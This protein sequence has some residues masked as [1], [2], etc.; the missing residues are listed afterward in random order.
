MIVVSLPRAVRCPS[1]VGRD[2]ELAAMAALFDAISA[3]IGGALIL[4]GDAGQ[5]KSRLV[6]EAAVRA[7]AAGIR[8][9]TG[10]ASA[11]AAVPYRVLS[12]AL[13]AMTGRQGPP[14]DRRIDPYRAILGKL[15]PGWASEAEPADMSAVAAGEAVLAVAGV[16][17]EPHGL[18]IALEDLHWADGETLAV[19]EYVTDNLAGYPVGLLLTSRPT[20]AAASRLGRQ[21]ASRGVAARAVLAPLTDGEAADMAA[22]CAAS[23]GRELALE[24]TTAVVTRSAGLPLLIEDLIA[25]LVARPANVAATAMPERFS[26]VVLQRLAALGAEAQQVVQAAAVLGPRFDWRLLGPVTTLAE[27]GIGA[28]IREAMDAQL[29][30]ADDHNGRPVFRHALTADV[31]V[32]DLDPSARA[33]LQLRAADALA[34]SGS[35]EPGELLALEARLRDAAGDSENAAALLIALA[36]RAA[37]VGALA[38]AEQHL[39][40]AVE[41][42]ADSQRARTLLLEVL[43][44]RG[45]TEP[46]LVLGRELLDSVRLVGEPRAV[47]ELLMA[48]AC[49]TAGRLGEARRHLTGAGRTTSARQRAEIASVQARVILADFGPDRVVAA[50]HLAHRAV[51]EAE[52]A[53]APELMCESLEVVGRCARLRDLDHARTAF[54]RALAVAD[55]HRLALWRIRALSELGTIEMF[56][57]VEPAGLIEA[58]RA[59]AAAGA[60]ATAA[61]VDVN[62]AAVHTMRAEFSP[63]RAAAE[64]CEALARRCGLPD[65]RAAG[66]VFQ[67]VV[68]THEGRFADMRVHVRAAEQLAGDDPDVIVGT[69]AMC[70]A[71]AALLREERDDARYAFATA[72]RSLARRPA[73]AIN[74]VDGPWLLLQVAAGEAGMG[75]VDDYAATQALGSRW[76]A[77][78][79]G[80]SR[81]IALGELGEPDAATRAAETAVTAGAPMPLFLAMGMRL[82]AERA[83]AAG[84][85]RPQPWLTAAERTFAAC[86]HARPAAACRDLL[87]A[88]GHRVPRQRAVD[89]AVPARL[90][91][92]GVTAREFDVFALVAR[93]CTNTEI[94]GR[95]Y[96]SPRTVEKH[97]A[98]LLAKTGTSSRIDLAR[99]AA[100]SIPPGEYGG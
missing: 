76:S 91:A 63:A 59:A 45:R 25:S 55:E 1:V 11:S 67:G 80:L 49:L 12:E 82:A 20:P 38:A 84:W 65:L 44:H 90:R 31:I 19:V 56:R 77:L 73:L 42:G 8:V 23:V 14:D 85:G 36:E 39:R 27:P 10:R 60:L 2:A 72:A 69:W 88:A 13:L 100:D 16:T 9:A 97:I 68:A 74:P 87:R 17:A 32:A 52:A 70:R 81:A 34:S 83:V 21:L 93:R 5:G 26:D 62:L 22:R 58:R 46:A 98:S 51:A 50:E 61:G 64:S 30:A 54:E 41:V 99:L 78:W 89:A 37:V 92:A 47:A 94:A 35:G 7:R 18:L 24:E 29:L 40:A 3:R 95:L 6:A 53:G 79:G 71:T 96:L 28:A 57:D 66:L 43:V 33:A 4:D 48:R 15:A 86:G 75:E